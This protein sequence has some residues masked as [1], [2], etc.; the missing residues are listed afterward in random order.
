ME[1]KHRHVFLSR[2]LLGTA[3][4][5]GLMAAGMV[6]PPVPLPAP[7]GVFTLGQLAAGMMMA[8]WVLLLAS[9]V[10]TQIE[11]RR[12]AFRLQGNSSL[13]LLAALSAMLIVTRTPLLGVVILGPSGLLAVWGLRGFFGDVIPLTNPRNYA[14]EK[15]AAKHLRRVDEA[16]RRR[17]RFLDWAERPAQ[18]A[19][20]CFLAAAAS[21]PWLLSVG[22]QPAWIVWAVPG[23][24]LV[25]AML[26]AV[27]LDRRLVTALQDWS[28]VGSKPY[29]QRFR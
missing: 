4:V 3:V 24:F 14:D 12:F 29:L 19:F 6:F 13:L 5:L 21:G 11:Q 2:A 7:P 8:S 26:L 27:V 15:T 10:K 18:A 23:A 25:V 9:F 17:R 28:Q 16:N 20:L 22:A 1:A